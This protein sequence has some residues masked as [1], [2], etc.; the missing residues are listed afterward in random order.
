MKILIKNAYVLD[1]VDDLP[2]IKKLDV[3]IKDDLIDKIDLEI[4]EEVDEI[5]DAKN[6]DTHNCYVLYLPCL[7]HLNT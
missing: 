2:N 6:K 4:N 3:L 1:M 5:I 7:L